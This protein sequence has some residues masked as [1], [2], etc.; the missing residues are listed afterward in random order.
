MGHEMSERLELL[1]ERILVLRD[2]AAR[3]GLTIPA[4]VIDYIAEKYSVP[5]AL[6]GALINVSAY[7]ARRGNPV[8]LE[9]AKLVLDG[10]R[11]ATSVTY[12]RDSESGEEQA[13]QSEEQAAQ[14]EE[15]QALETQA[16]EQAPISSQQAQPTPGHVE[17]AASLAPNTPIEP[18]SAYAVDEPVAPLTPAPAYDTQTSLFAEEIFSPDP[19]VAEVPTVIT[20]ESIESDDFLTKESEVPTTA[21]GP[22][23]KVFFVPM[24]THRKKSLIERV[25]TALNRAGLAEIIAPGDKVAIKVHFGERGNTGF[26]SPIYAREVVRMVKE[27][28]G[29]PFLTDANTLYSGQRDNGID[30]IECALSH[31]FSFATVEAPIIIADGIDGRDGIDVPIEGKHYDAVRLGS[32]AVHADAM[33]VISHV[34]GHGEAGFGGAIKNIGMGLGTRAAKQR[35]HSD[36]KPVV[37]TENCTRCG[38]C[39]EWCPVNCIEIGPLPHERAFI[40]PEACIGCGE[41]VA[42]CAYNAI[43]V[44]WK[45]DN[46]VFQ[47]KMVE[48]AL[49]ILNSKHGKIAYVSFLT[50]ITPECDC[51][52]FSDA[53]IVPDIGVLASRDIVAIEQASLD[54]VKEAVGSK[55]TLGEGIQSGID[56]FESIHKIDGSIAIRYAESLGM[57]TSQYT[58]SEVG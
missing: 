29:K 34:K 46:S 10:I 36:A 11:P 50:N 33:V 45:T 12:P 31:G 49:G 48:H 7:A 19:V 24:R 54:L 4:D 23:P 55:G 30:H 8:T 58:L 39:V 53:P 42:A 15:S 13:A 16:E 6:K 35:M 9:T 57:G 40:D 44:N 20:E 51:W 43:Q 32:A 56:K 22:K 3:E 14:S 18:S 52:S 47:E 26:V 28:G 27:L 17:P 1:E 21:Q 37:T 25:G 41:C 38:R 2:K 5:Q